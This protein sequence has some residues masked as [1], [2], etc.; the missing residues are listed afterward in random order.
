MYINV[1]LLDSLG[2]SHPNK[3]VSKAMVS[4]FAQTNVVIFDVLG[5]APVKA[6]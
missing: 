5:L 6:C 3:L 2:D 4:A 1:L